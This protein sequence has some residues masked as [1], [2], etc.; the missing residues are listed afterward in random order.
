MQL[1]PF[2][3]NFLNR[4]KRKLAKMSDEQHIRLRYREVHGVELNLQNPLNFNEKLLWLNLYE[5]NPLK[6]N[7]ADKY[8]VR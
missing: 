7:C 1:N 5:R 8:A 6:T 2:H 3:K 4:Y